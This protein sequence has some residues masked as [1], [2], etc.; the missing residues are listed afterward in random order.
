MLQDLIYIG[1]GLTITAL[2]TVGICIG[3]IIKDNGKK[4]DVILDSH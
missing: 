3:I 4:S 1:I 2:F